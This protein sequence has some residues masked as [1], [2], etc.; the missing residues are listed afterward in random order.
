MMSKSDLQRLKK[1]S[2]ATYEGSYH[3]D[4]SISDEEKIAKIFGGR[5]KGEN[6]QSSSR[7]TRGEP[8][9]IAGITVPDKPPQPD[10]CCMSGCINCVWE[11]FEEDLKHWNKK[12]KQ[13]AKALVEKGGRWPE[14]FLAPV[15]WL[16]KENLPL[17]LAEGSKPLADESSDPWGDIPVSIRVFAQFEKRLKDRREARIKRSGA[18]ALT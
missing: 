9:V 14:R 18:E 6:R 15:K 17:S 10:N 3:L 5:I 8:R 13:A 1:Q 2:G 11:I 12:R 16:P 4:K 7:I